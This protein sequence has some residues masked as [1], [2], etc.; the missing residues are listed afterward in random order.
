MIYLLRYGPAHLHG[1]RPEG[2]Q[3]PARD[4]RQ[5][6]H[7]L[8]RCRKAQAAGDS[9]GLSPTLSE[10][11]F[12]ARKSG[13]YDGEIAAVRKSDALRPLRLRRRLV[14]GTLRAAPARVGSERAN[15]RLDGPADRR[16]R[17][18][19]ALVT[20]NDAH[21][22]RVAGLRVVNWLKETAGSA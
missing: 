13:N 15:H 6:A 17:D 21:F 18:G 11:E 20:D 12:G 14:P 16:P 4:R 7:L 10:L 2:G 3:P 1:P 5:A 22:S 19:P 8:D 9:V